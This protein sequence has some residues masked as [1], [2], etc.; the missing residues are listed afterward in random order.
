MCFGCCCRCFAFKFRTSI[1]V[2]RVYGYAQNACSLKTQTTKHNKCACVFCF[3]FFA[4]TKP[5]LKS[6]PSDLLIAIVK[7]SQSVNWCEM[8]ERHR[9]KAVNVNGFKCL[10]NA[11]NCHSNLH[12]NR[13]RSSSSSS[14]SLPTE[15]I[16][17]I[18]NFHAEKNAHT[19]KWKTK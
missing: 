13:N 4:F 17:W 11:S 16:K 6:N 10:K 5:E 1:N 19:T 12:L 3:C 7:V 8:S 2:Y 14:S 9:E 18:R 15:I